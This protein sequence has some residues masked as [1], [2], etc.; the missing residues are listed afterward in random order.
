MAC[1][2]FDNSTH[3]QI[4][5][6]DLGILASTR[7]KPVALADVYVRDEVKMPMQACL[8]RQRISIPNL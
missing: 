7:N 5:D 1:H 3:L 8:Q 6:D 4:P 2:P